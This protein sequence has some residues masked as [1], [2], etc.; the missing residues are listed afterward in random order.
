MVKY[1]FEPSVSQHKH[2][3]HILSDNSKSVLIKNSC[4]FESNNFSL[5]H[6][7]INL[8]AFNFNWRLLDKDSEI[9]FISTELQFV[10][11]FP[12]LNLIG[13]KVRFVIHEPNLPNNSVNFI[14][15]NIIHYFLLKF[16]HKIFSFKNLKNH[17]ST[18]INLW[19]DIPKNINI[20]SNKSILSFG[21]E[22]KNKRIDLLDIDWGD[23]NF[24]RAGKTTHTFT[25]V[26][27]QN[28]INSFITNSHKDKLFRENSFSIIPYDFIAQSSVFIEAISYGHII[29]LNA[30][31]KC[32][33][34]YH[35][36][37]FVFV[38]NDSPK[39]LLTLLTSLTSKEIKSLREKSLDYFKENYD[40]IYDI[41][42]LLA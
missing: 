22:T 23:I 2:L 20:L 26:K 6:K 3:S 27:N 41:R 16:C 39:E 15:R 1:I 30:N 5:I 10:F 11:L 36:L 24:T 19:F 42:T 7:L 32:W 21:S 17:H 33:E 25:K 12:Y 14:S 34:K 18:I 8:K 29:I 28:I 9:L 35:D 31:N 40:P 4:S 38:F 37:D 13:H